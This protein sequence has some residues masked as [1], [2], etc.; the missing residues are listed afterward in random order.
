MMEHTNGN[1]MEHTDAWW[2]GVE[3]IHVPANDYTWCL[4][5]IH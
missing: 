5:I 2:E 1:F 3:F 4:T